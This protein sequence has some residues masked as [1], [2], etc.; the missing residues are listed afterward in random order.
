MNGSNA[1]STSPPTAPGVGNGARDRGEAD[2]PLLHDGA[3]RME[4]GMEG[5]SRGNSE[6]T[7]SGGQAKPFLERWAKSGEG[8]GEADKPSPASRPRPPA[9]ADDGTTPLTESWYSPSNFGLPYTSGGQ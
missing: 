5:V 9:T 2:T 7:F 4:G 3:R 8:R 6:P 1:T